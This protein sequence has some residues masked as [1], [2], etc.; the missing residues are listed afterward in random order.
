MRDPIPAAF[1]PRLRAA[2]EKAG[3]TQQQAADA[4]GILRTTYTRIEQGR[5]TSLEYARRLADAVGASLDDLCPPSR[6]IDR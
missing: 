5:P 2:R 6:L 3:L 4:A 1:G